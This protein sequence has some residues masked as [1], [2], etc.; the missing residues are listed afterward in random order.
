M[1]AVLGG[2]WNVM[3]L[4]VELL[5]VFVAIAFSLLF[6]CYSSCLPISHSSSVYNRLCSHSGFTRVETS[7]TFSLR[8]LRKRL[9]FELVNIQREVIIFIEVS[10]Y[11]GKPNPNT[12]TH[13]HAHGRDFTTRNFNHEFHTLMNK[14]EF[15]KM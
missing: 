1:R 12:H 14:T 15:H 7:N 5:V 2:M 10:I 13:F 9:S 8:F 3:M 6:I 4:L 11:D